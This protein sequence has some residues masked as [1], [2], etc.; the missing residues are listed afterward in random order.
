MSWCRFRDFSAMRACYQVDDDNAVNCD[1]LGEMAHRGLGP[2]LIR[3]FLREIVFT[4]ASV[5][6]CVIDPHSSNTI[7]IRAY[8]KASFTFMREVIDFEDNVPL[9]LMVLSRAELA[10]ELESDVLVADREP[11]LAADPRRK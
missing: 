9:H 5:T 2:G 3:K 7:A 1:V 11:H 6:N 10:R 8:A 4:D